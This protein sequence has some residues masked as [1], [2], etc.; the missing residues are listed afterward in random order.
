[1]R[2]SGQLSSSLSL[3][4]ALE[5]AVASAFVRS[6]N[7]RRASFFSPSPIAI[8][9]LSSSPIQP[10]CLWE[11]IDSSKKEVSPTCYFPAR[12]AILRLGLHHLRPGT[13]AAVCVC[14]G[15]PRPSSC[16]SLA[17]INYFRTRL[18]R[19]AAPFLLRGNLHTSAC[20]SVPSPHQWFVALGIAKGQRIP[21]QRTI[22][23]S[24]TIEE[25]VKKLA[26]MTQRLE[27]EVAAAT[28]AATA[29]P[30]E[31]VASE[32]DAAQSTKRP[33]EDT[34]AAMDAA[35]EASA[36]D[37]VKKARFDD[38]ATRGGKKKWERRD[39]RGT[40]RSDEREAASE[41]SGSSGD[42]LPKRK[43]AV[44]FGYCGI[45]YSGLQINPG[46][47]TIEGDIFDAFCTAGASPRTT[48]STR[49]R[50]ACNVPRARIA[51]FMRPETC[52]RSNSSCNPTACKRAR[53]WWTRSTRCCPSSS[54]SGA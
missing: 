1:M 51:V 6:T 38:S 24:D 3:H 11:E 23:D 41:P 39:R 16:D 36:E 22:L 35:T 45:G 42:R 10:N 46:V 20:L 50:W 43:V 31:T 4:C 26:S 25:K 19:A 44:K 32:A 34:S 30:A 37:S 48:R 52:S 40:G 2:C 28:S 9:S 7:F 5:L 18:C 49:T 12:T 33:L 17:N 27:Q 54:G 8:Y 29:A 21:V 53:R 14:A 13:A 15:S 47:K